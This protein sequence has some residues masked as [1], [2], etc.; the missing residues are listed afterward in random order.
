MW[1]QRLTRILE[2]NRSVGSEE[3]GKT[4]YLERDRMFSCSYQV[5]RTESYMKQM[6][7]EVESK[8]S[9]THQS[10]FVW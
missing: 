1:T 8:S 3:I 10:I 6:T 7:I 2:N 9:G 4:T 5:F